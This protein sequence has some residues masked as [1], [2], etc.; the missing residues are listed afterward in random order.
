[1]SKV[2]LTCIILHNTMVEE[3]YVDCDT[4]PEPSVQ[5]NAL[6]PQVQHHGVRDELACL[7]LRSDLVERVWQIHGEILLICTFHISVVS[8]TCFRQLCNAM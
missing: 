5:G 4:Q 8:H 6:L 7:E 1:M 3:G 2:M